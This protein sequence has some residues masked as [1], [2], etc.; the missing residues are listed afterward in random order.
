M[1]DHS[2]AVFKRLFGQTEGFAVT[3]DE[4]IHFFIEIVIRNFLIRMGDIH[5]FE[6]RIVITGLDHFFRKAFGIFP[7]EIERNIFTHNNFSFF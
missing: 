6:R 1:Q 2:S 5:H 4:L 3:A 7:A